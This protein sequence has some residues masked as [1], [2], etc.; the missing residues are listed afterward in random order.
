MEN[1][2]ADTPSKKSLRNQ[3]GPGRI[4]DFYSIYKSGVTLRLTKMAYSHLLGGK[5]AFENLLIFEKAASGAFN[6][7]NTVFLSSTVGVRSPF[8]F[9]QALY[10][11][12]ATR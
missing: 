9:D 10:T 1:P 7:D 6:W 4:T 12:K 8:I 3:I 11:R 2:P 5:L